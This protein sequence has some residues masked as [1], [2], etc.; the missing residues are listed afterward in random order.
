MRGRHH[1]DARVPEV[2]ERK[3]ERGVSLDFVDRRHP[4][5]R[6]RRNHSDA[7]EGKQDEQGEL[8]H[9]SEPNRR[10]GWRAN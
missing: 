7:P 3:A 9:G 10:N 6:G 2:A 1:E 8:F 5:L 4:H